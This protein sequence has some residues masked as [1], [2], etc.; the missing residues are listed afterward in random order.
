MKDRRG[1]EDRRGTA[2]KTVNI[3]VEWQGSA[4]RQAGTVSDISVDG[5]FVLS[6][7]DI[8]DGE[9]VRVFIPLGEGMKAEFS[10][11]VANHAVEIGFAIR[12]D[13]LSAPQRELLTA[14]IDDAV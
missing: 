13:Q 8:T 5:C 2:R 11:R 9:P 12:F 1:G 14:I 4:A 3:D 7:G 10:G 6:S